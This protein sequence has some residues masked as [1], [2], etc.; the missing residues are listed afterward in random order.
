MLQND[1]VKY[2]EL[3]RVSKSELKIS[4]KYYLQTHIIVNK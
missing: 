1:S 4:S 2:S 3:S